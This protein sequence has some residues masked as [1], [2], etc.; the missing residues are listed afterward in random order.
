MRGWILTMLAVVGVVAG[1]AVAALL[2]WPAGAVGASSSGLAAVSVPGFSGRIE[3]VSVTGPNGTKLPYVM[4]GNTVWPSARLDAGERVTVTGDARR[5][6]GAG[7]LVGTRVRRTF[8]VHT[9]VAQ[10]RSTLL[11]PK[12]GSA[13]TVRF[14]EPVASVRIGSGRH[15]TVGGHNVVPLG[16][17]ATGAA[18]AGTTT[19]AAAARPWERLS[20]PARVSWFVPGPGPPA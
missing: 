20:D 4:R 13:V 8:T 5:P 7:W 3:H 10:I 17:V 6:T 16:I 15:R 11:R 2:A 9:P 1:C 12:R 18:T 19:V 14:A